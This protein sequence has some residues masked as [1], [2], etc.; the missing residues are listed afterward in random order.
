VYFF[1]AQPQERVAEL[2]R[3]S[4]V[5]LLPSAFEGMPISVLEALGCGLPVVST[6]V[7]EVKRVV[8]NGFSGIISS[9][10]EP[11]KLGDSVLKIFTKQNEL[12]AENCLLSIKDYTASRILG[13]VYQW[14]RAG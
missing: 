6:D 14:F 3:V 12:S 2:M 7:G 10:Q 11:A 13:K 1:G 9:E 8:R 5:F 4:D